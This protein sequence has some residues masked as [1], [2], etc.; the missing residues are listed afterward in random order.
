MTPANYIKSRIGSPLKNI[1]LLFML[2]VS[3]QM[4][5]F[6]FF[7]TPTSSSYFMSH[8]IVCYFLSYRAHPRSGSVQTSPTSTPMSSRRGRQLPQLPP[9]G[10]DRSKSPGCLF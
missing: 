2:L 3:D 8:A 9:A 5:A 6:L 1:V 7:A 10:K 4:Y